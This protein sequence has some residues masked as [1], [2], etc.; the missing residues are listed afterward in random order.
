MN[1]KQHKK[2]VAEKKSELI[3]SGWQLLVVPMIGIGYT[4]STVANLVIEF[5]IISWQ[6]LFLQLS[7]CI[8]TNYNEITEKDMF[9]NPINDEENDELEEDF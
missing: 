7:R 3:K 1:R 5:D 6:F 4:K 8:V 9:D 2:L